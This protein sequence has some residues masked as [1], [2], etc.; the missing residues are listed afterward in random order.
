M[1]SRVAAAKL[2]AANWNA[3]EQR[4]VVS[5]GLMSEPGAAGFAG[6]ARL[7]AQSES[8]A[9]AAVAMREGLAPIAVQAS[10]APLTLTRFDA[11]LVDQL[12][13]ATSPH[14]SSR[15]PPPPA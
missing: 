11:L 12:G 14:T 5:E 4:L 9:L 15:P 2:T 6:A 1:P 3:S 7:S 10:D 13:L 8:S